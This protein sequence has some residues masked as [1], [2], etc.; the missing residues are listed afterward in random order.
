MSSNLVSDF[1]M[2]WLYF[3][4]II[5]RVS[6]VGRRIE[7]ISLLIQHRSRG[8]YLISFGLLTWGILHHNLLFWATGLRLEAP[9]Y[10]IVYRY[11]VEEGQVEVKPI[12]LCV[13]KPPPCANGFPNILS[14]IS[15][16]SVKKIKST[17][18]PFLYIEDRNGVKYKDVCFS[19]RGSHVCISSRGWNY[20]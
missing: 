7:Y 18:S 17:N 9:K 10:F 12:F 5:T 11:V 3:E 2:F 15:R 16:V 6:V 19:M 8:N 1:T 20:K 4:E 13:K 14:Q